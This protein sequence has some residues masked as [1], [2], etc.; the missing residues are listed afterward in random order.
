[1]K[2]TASKKLSQQPPKRGTQRR[3]DERRQQLLLAAQAL[4]ARHELQ[5]V[6]YAAVCAEA[7]VPPGSAHHFYPDLDS[8][9]HAVLEM[10]RASFDAALMRPLAPR[11][12]DS[13]QAVVECFID[14]AVRYHRAHPVEAKLAVGGLMPMHLKRFDRDADRSIARMILR[15]LEELFV[16][17]RIPDRE[18]IAYIS[19]QIVDMTFTLS[20]S[21]FGR[22]TPEYAQYAKLATIGFLKQYFGEALE[23]RPQG[24]AM[25]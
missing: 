21:G 19:T 6:T 7:G 13:W 11:D 12:C 3:G 5:A 4:L 10:H 14:R 24:P 22:I 2:S 20:M 16:V 18:E 17:P 9:Y 23:S 8:I 25:R 1:V 15:A